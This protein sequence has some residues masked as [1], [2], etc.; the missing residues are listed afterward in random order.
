MDFKSPAFI[1][2]VV[3][4]FVLLVVSLILGMKYYKE[5]RRL[6][7]HCLIADVSQFHSYN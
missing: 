7:S 6:S 5:K 4:N 3:L 2:W 1:E